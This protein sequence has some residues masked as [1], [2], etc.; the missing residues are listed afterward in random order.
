MRSRKVAVGLAAAAVLMA[1]GVAVAAPALA[2]NGPGGTVP[3]EDCP[4]EC[5]YDQEQARE[6]MREHARDHRADPVHH[7][8]RA[9]PGDG[10]C[11]RTW[12]E[13]R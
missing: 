3:R 1:G 8:H 4:V 10:T 7:W 12:E 5:P 11:W 6:Q 9:R 2:G 13:T